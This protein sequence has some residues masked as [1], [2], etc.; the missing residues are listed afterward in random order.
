MREA[1]QNLRERELQ[2]RTQELD[3]RE[4]DLRNASQGVSGEL[5]DS[6]G[7]VYPDLVLNIAQKCPGVDMKYINRIYRNTFDPWDLIRLRPKKLEAE[8]ALSTTLEGGKL[9]LK[10]SAYSAKDYASITFWADCFANWAYIFGLLFPQHPEVTC[11]L[12][13]YLSL[14]LRKAIVYYDS[15]LITFAI[16]WHRNILASSLFVAS[17]WTSILEE[18]LAELLPPSA[19]R[20]FNPEGNKRQRAE[21]K[22]TKPLDLNDSTVICARFN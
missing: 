5:E 15:D 11:A 3:K 22:S 16:S 4:A 10:R 1:E 6:I 9:V 17:N 8:E 18:W 2:I 12:F 7:K 14:I 21:T 20:S 13:K 19:A